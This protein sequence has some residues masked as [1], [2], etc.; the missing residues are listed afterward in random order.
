MRGR[1]RRRGKLTARDRLW[2]AVAER[3][4]RTVAEAKAAVSEQEFRR[5]WCPYLA[6]EPSVG[7]RLDWWGSQILALMVNVHRSKGTK[8]LAA[9]DVLPDRWGD[10]GPAPAPAAARFRGKDLHDMLRAL[11]GVPASGA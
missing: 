9:A 8:P 4:G 3:T 1:G 2:L 6:R 10:R 11:A 5:L 7:D